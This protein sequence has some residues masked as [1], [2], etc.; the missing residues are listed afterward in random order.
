MR[1]DCGGASQMAEDRI[2]PYEHPTSS[3]AGQGNDDSNGSKETLQ[4]NIS[5]FDHIYVQ[6]KW[7]KII[8]ISFCP[9]SNE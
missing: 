9:F 7:S 3:M 2:V 8:V 5:H 6:Q 4:E 1:S